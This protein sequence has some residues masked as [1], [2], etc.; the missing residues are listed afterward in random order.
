[1]LLTKS[2]MIY[3]GVTRTE[4]CVKLMV[5]IGEDLCTTDVPMMGICLP[6]GGGEYIHGYIHLN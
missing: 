5:H 2:M 1:M 6:V 4:I 3:S